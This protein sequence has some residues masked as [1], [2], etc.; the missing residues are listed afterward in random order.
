MAILIN[1][2]VE[3]LSEKRQNLLFSATLSEQVRFL[4]K[5]AIDNAVEIAITPD[6]TTTPQ[7]DQWL[8]T[9]DKENKSALLS[10]LITEYKWNQ[11]LIFIE[12]K[13]GAAK[14]VSPLE[15]RGIKAEAIHSGRSQAVRAQLLEDFKSGELNLL[16]AT[17]IAARGID[18][19]DLVHTRSVDHNGVFQNRFKTPFSSRVASSGNDIDSIGIGKF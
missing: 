2:I 12:T 1:K 13:R 14:L 9:V 5:T 8:I 3:R 19:D 4:A 7:I 16:V 6:S 10:H 18:I 17:G 11:A 15:K